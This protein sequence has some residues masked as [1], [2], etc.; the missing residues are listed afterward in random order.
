MN[1]RRNSIRKLQS[2]SGQGMIESALVFTILVFMILGLID[3]AFVFQAYIGVVNAAGVGATYGATSLA[4]ANNPSAI[5]AA[6]LS[7]SDTWHCSSQW[8]TSST[9]TDSFGYTMVSVT[10]HC[11]VADL[12]AIP[13]A[14]NQITVSST[15]IRRVRP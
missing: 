6:A 14:F 9:S 2:E 3:F 13:D 8:V 10:V 1:A 4:A 5:S 12:I 15:A 11:Q 7:E